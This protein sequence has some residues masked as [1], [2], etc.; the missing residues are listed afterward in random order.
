MPG[1][2]QP[3]WGWGVVVVD[4]THSA[5]LMGQ[6]PNQYRWRALRDGLS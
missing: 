3:A 1:K 6:L 4:N 5:V 2:K